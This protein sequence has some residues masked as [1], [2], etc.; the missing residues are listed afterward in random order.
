MH[1]EGRA[2]CAAL[3]KTSSPTPVCRHMGAIS[4]LVALA[5]PGM[6]LGAGSREVDLP[7]ALDLARR[8]NP[9]LEAA[10]RRV[11]EARGELTGASVL[12]RE[13]PEAE[14]AAGR[15]MPDPGAEAG[16]KPF[17]LGVAQRFEIAGQRGKR[18]E[19]ASEELAAVEAEEEVAGRALDLSVARAFYEG[20]G[21]RE[22]SKVAQQNE[23]LARELAA[24]AEARVARGAA[25]ALESNAAR[26]RVAEASRRLLAARAEERASRLRLAALLGLGPEGDVVLGGDLPEA[27]P[28]PAEAPR[29]AVA[30]RPEVRAAE[31]RTNAARAAAELATRSG[32]PDV[33]LGARYSH[34]EASRSVVGTL[35][36]PIPLFQ[37]NQGERERSEA[38]ALR[39]EA[40]ER[41]IRLQVAT[42]AEEARLGL[43]RAR[44]GLALYDADVLRALGESLALLR[45]ALDAGKVS[46]AE[47]IVLQRE[48]LEGRLGYLEARVEL[49]VADALARTAAGLPI[50]SAT[51]GGR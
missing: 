43:E 16:R 2:A 25:T 11:G 14:V 12:L 9:G 10:R 37:R 34:E 50:V 7:A 28:L 33:V 17:E 8:N 22:R 4:L 3:L 40:E 29:D 19:R 44:A 39:A 27:G 1:I 21:A 20:L 18:V 26:V 41:A 32:F 13:N 23:E 38:A 24:I 31:R 51:G 46:P 36:V 47:V 45:R 48:L 42:A 5:A 6:A 35:S 30:T 49:A 15:R